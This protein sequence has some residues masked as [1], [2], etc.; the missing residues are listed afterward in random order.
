MHI[1]LLRCYTLSSFSFQINW[2]R[3]DAW[4]CLSDFDPSVYLNEATRLTTKYKIK[5][6]TQQRTVREREHR[7]QK[8]N[9][10]QQVWLLGVTNF[11][12]IINL[13]LLEVM[14]NVYFAITV[15]SYS[16]DRIKPTILAMFQDVNTGAENDT[17]LDYT[18]P[19]NSKYYS[20]ARNMR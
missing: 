5:N 3:L 16:Y 14:I 8:I 15:L 6:V 12:V 10:V 19:E 20:V 4:C 1:R 7:Q 11:C 18:H 2:N 9:I 13:F 17:G